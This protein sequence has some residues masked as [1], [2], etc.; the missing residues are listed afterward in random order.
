GAELTLA[1]ESFGLDASAATPSRL[2]LLAPDRERYKNLC[3]M[4]TAAKL[5]IIGENP[6]GSSRYPVKGESRVMLE[7]L[8]QFGAGMI[9]LAGGASSPVARMLTRGDDPRTLCDRLA[10]ILGRNNLY[11]DLQRH[12]DPD[13]E[14]LNRKFTALA[15]VCGIPLV[16]T[17]GVC[18]TLGAPVSGDAR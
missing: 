18:F 6:D 9:C 7:E 11:L 14:R 15:D 10:S 1:D 12:L 13:E 2:Y 3:R 17:N 8:E 5:R 16:A 4:I